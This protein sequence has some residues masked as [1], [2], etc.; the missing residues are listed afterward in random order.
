M[1]GRVC[2]KLREICAVPVRIAREGD[3]EYFA[4]LLRLVNRAA[5]LH[6]DYGPFVR[7]NSTT[8]FGSKVLMLA[9]GCAGVGDWSDLSTTYLEYPAQRRGW[10]GMH[11]APSTMARRH[12]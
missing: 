6:A 1:L 11:S 12:R 7:C 3:I 8:T 2:Q 9:L 10:W 5:K 4:G